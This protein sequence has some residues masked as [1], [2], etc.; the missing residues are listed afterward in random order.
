M[1]T[2]DL[3]YSSAVASCLLKKDSIAMGKTSFAGNDVRLYDSCRLSCMYVPKCG[4][5]DCTAV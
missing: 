3:S 5:T 2:I 1:L 4:V